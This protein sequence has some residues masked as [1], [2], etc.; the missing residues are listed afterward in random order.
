MLFL[1]N[2]LRFVS[3]NCNSV[4]NKIE[5]VKILS[6]NFDI[7]LLQ[8]ILL[9]ESDTGYLDHISSEHY[10]YH[11]V[12]DKKIDNINTGRPSKGVFF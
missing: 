2:M 7:V 10:A 11:L 1:F 4:R 8:E 5:T 3:Y 9:L 12:K 6:S